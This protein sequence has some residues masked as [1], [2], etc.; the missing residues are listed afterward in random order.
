MTFPSS[1]VAFIAIGIFDYLLPTLFLGSFLAFVWG[2]FQ[3]FI[4]GSS[5]EEVKE[6]AKALMLYGFAVFFLMLVIWTF[7]TIVIP[8]RP[9]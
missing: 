4:H 7:F 8:L 5:D 2:T 9:A 1:I 6:K 3:Y